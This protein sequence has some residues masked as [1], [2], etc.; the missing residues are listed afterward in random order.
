M[1][2]FINAADYGV[3]PA[4][5]NN[6]PDLITAIAAAAGQTLLISTPGTY[7]IASRTVIT[8]S[9]V[10]IYCGPDVI[11]QDNGRPVN[12]AT[13]G[14][15]PRRLPW[16]I[17]FQNCDNLFWTGGWFRTGT[18]FN[19]GSSGFFDPTNYA[20]RNP[21][22][23]FI[24]GQG[25]EFNVDGF[26]G[27]PGVGMDSAALASIVAYETGLKSNGTATVST[28]IGSDRITVTAVGSGVVQLGQ[29]ITA[30]GISAYS[31]I[32]EQIS[33]TAGGTG[34]YRMTWRAT[35]TATGVAATLTGGL[36]SA[37]V[38]Y[39]SLRCAIFCAYMSK[40]AKVVVASLGA[41]SRREQI[42]MAGCSDYVWDVSDRSSPASATWGSAGKIIDCDR[43]T[44]RGRGTNGGT[45]S[46]VDVIGDDWSADI[47][48][49]TPGKCIDVS[50]E[51]QAA[52][53]PARGGTVEYAR[54][55]NPLGYS[56]TAVGG[57]STGSQILAAPIRDL[58]V[59]RALGQVQIPNVTVGL[60]EESEFEN[61][62]FP[63]NLPT[64][65][66][67]TQVI[68]RCRYTWSD[69][70]LTGQRAMFR[71]SK[72]LTLEQCVLIA[73]GGPALTFDQ[74]ST[75]GLLRFFDCTLTDIAITTYVNV[76]LR[77]CI[78]TNVTWT[79]MSGATVTNYPV[80]G[81][82]L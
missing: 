9:N 15:P 71:I 82:L 49:D 70:A 62:G 5:S 1:A 36:T 19:G 35:I 77:G 46:F 40:A 21:A 79:K 58:V 55:A 72:L 25:W 63:S 48:I 44:I 29:R 74:V 47:R 2:D 41:N 61:T 23:E 16:G 56:V 7:V 26:D 34:V 13:V 60:F 6:G 45:G 10:R 37:E 30:T 20:Q 18:G 39:I 32:C 17:S 57:A 65:T 80:T 50:H 14:N 78:L 51:W 73:T 24:G 28:V 31:Y 69:S 3:L 52:N 54:N 42:T 8:T 64:I 27:D 67:G 11:F 22:V 12:S 59:R 4:S 81:V 43:G 66:D 53:R 38:A 75:G 76:E 33:G 68:S